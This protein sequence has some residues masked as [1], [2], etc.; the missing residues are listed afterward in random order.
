MDSLPHADFILSAVVGLLVSIIF[1]KF[2]SGPAFFPKETEESDEPLHTKDATDNNKE[3]NYKRNQ[4]EE[5]FM[6]TINKEHA[7]KKL[8]PIQNVLGLS[9]EQIANAIQ[10]T[11][12]E[13][14]NQTNGGSETTTNK[15][16]KEGTMQVDMAST[17]VS[18]VD[19]VVLVS[20]LLFGFYVI[21][22]ASHGDLGRMVSAMF[23]EETSSLRMKDFLDNF[24][25]FRKVPVE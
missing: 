16:S 15:A 10:M 18:I 17:V 5:N 13:I 24:Y 4:M 9:K 6:P 3:V 20:A 22:V 19:T 25:M 8:T 23:P 12:D 1:I 7:L 21:N 2:G 11:N 14:A